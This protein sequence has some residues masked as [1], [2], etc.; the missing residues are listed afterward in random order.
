ML[1]WAHA[2]SLL[3]TAS[4]LDQRPTSPPRLAA[5]APPPALLF[6]Q[7]ADVKV[8][9]TKAAGHFFDENDLPEAC[10]PLLSEP[11]ALA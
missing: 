7:F 9:A 5:S 1:A 11:R 10:R 8:M 2:H 6:T 3:L 4:S